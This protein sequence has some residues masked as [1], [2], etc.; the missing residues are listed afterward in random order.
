MNAL[1]CIMIFV[2]IA[3]I[4]YLGYKNEKNYSRRMEE[5]RLEE[6]EGTDR[7]AAFVSAKMSLENYLSSQG[8]EHVMI[9]LSEILPRQDP[10]SGKFKHIINMQSAE[11][12]D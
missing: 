6:K 10:N 8:I 4:Y 3:F 12:T 5:M 7:T 1:I 11:S 2:T 9:T